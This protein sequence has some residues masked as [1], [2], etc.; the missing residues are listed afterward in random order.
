[1][2]IHT[3]KDVSIQEARRLNSLSLTSYLHSFLLYGLFNNGCIVRT[4]RC[5]L[6]IKINVMLTLLRM[7]YKEPERIRS[8]PRFHKTSFIQSNETAC[9]VRHLNGS[10]TFPLLL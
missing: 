6:L 10:S 1:M 3:A 2:K 7:F 8:T 4:S 9:T 5:K